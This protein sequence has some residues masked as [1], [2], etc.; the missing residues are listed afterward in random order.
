MN[1]HNTNTILKIWVRKF[2]LTINSTRTKQSSIQY[3]NSIGSHNH[4]NILR[5]LKPIQLIQQFKHRSLHFR[6]STTRTAACTSNTINLIHKN[7]T[8]SSLTRHHKQLT[9]HTRTFPNILLH[10][11]STRHTHKGTIRMMRHSPRQQRLTRPRRPIQQHTLRLRH[12]QR[13]KQLRMLN[14]QLNHLLNLHHLLLQST[15]HIVRTIRD[16]LH[17]HKRHEGIYLGR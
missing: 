2:N 9:N 11:L 3:I 17:L 4:L 8:R 13:L 5:R 16:C 6:I 10:K 12:T 15:N 14:R 7:Y 1:L